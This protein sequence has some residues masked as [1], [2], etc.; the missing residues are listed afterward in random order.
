MPDSAGKFFLGDYINELVARGFD[1]FSSQDLINLVNRGYFKV[2][3]T[4][5][6]YWEETY[7]SFHLEPGFFYVTLWPAVGGELPNFR[8]LDKLYCVT[9]EYSNRLNALDDDDFF[10]N[11]LPLDLTS[12][13][14]QSEPDS[15]Y[16][17]EGKL[18]VLP[19]PNSPRDYVAHYHQ[20]VSAMQNPAS[21]QPLTPIHLD[22]AILL[23]ALARCHERTQE[24]SLAA[25]AKG[26]LEEAFDDMRD[27]EEFLMAEQAT[28]VGR[29]DTWI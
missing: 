22:E 16:V 28:R 3:R 25:A 18:Y 8:S 29:D 24:L 10:T 21:D 12:T 7:D 19:P 15:Y 13:S 5:R 1:G 4:H 2:A 26:N 6:W 23:A 14:A 11:Y 17:Y 9:S 20:R 27:D